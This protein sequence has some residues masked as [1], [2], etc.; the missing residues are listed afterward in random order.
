[1]IRHLNLDLTR[2]QKL[3]DVGVDQ[4]RARSLH[5][6]GLLEGLL[7]ITAHVLQYNIRFCLSDDIIK[8]VQWDI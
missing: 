3:S 5:N 2:L 4:R 7:G 6:D 8:K 1:M